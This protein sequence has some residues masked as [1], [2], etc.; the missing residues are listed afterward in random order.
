MAKAIQVLIYRVGSNLTRKYY[1]GLERP[2]TDEHSSL[3]QIAV[4]YGHKKIDYINYLY[5][6]Y[7]SC[8]SIDSTLLFS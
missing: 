4:Y 2:S 5:V 6:Y 3:L 8:Y 1:S 7:Y